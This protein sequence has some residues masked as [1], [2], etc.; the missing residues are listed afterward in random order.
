VTA[1]L[2][3]ATGSRVATR[4]SDND[5]QG[6]G[7]AKRTSGTS[8]IDFKAKNPLEAFQDPVV[9]W[10]GAGVLGAQFARTA[11]YENFRDTFGK[12]VFVDSGDKSKGVRYISKNGADIPSARTARVL[13]NMGIV[14]L[15]T[16][17]L[18][19]QAGKAENDLDIF[20]LGLAASGAANVVQE[21][22]QI[23]P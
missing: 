2:D 4:T 5:E 22:F 14:L 21:L 1:R 17:L 23:Y 11:M 13:A 6:E 3:G 12:A 10:T 7:M 20:G 18:T 16:L 9:L 15:G 19:S 8:E